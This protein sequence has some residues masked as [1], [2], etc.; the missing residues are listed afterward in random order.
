MK[1]AVTLEEINFKY[2]SNN[3]D[4]VLHNVNCGFPFG[5]YTV[6]IGHNGSGKSTLSKIVTGIIKPFSGNVFVGSTKISKT[7]LVKIRKNIGIVFQNPDNQFIGTT[8]KN[9]IIFGLE[10]NCVPPSEME[11]IIEKAAKKAGVFHLYERAPQLLSGGQ[12]QKVA[13]AGIL[14]LKNDIIIFDEATSMLDPR[15]KRDIKQIMI[16]LGKEKNKTIIS[17]THDME[18]VINADHVLVMDKGKVLMEGTPAEIFSHAET[19]RKVGLDTPLT[20]TVSE[21]LSKFDK[22]FKPTIFFKEF[23]KQCQ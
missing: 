23:I 2:N 22:S 18:E 11:A 6:I 13:I 10:N 8:V 1:N 21:Y 20:Y 9:D 5:K 4:W 15:G 17:I 3:K 16:E 7:N 19:L 12:K 14:A